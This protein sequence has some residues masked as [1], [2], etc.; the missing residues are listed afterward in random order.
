MGSR[1]KDLACPLVTGPS[2]P[3][4]HAA[5]D[6]PVRYDFAFVYGFSGCTGMRSMNGSDGMSGTSGTMGSMDPNNPSPG[7]NG[8]DGTNGSDG[9]EGSLG[10][11]AP[12]VDVRMALQ[13]GA[14]P[15]L[16]VSVSAPGHRRVYLVDPQ[17]VM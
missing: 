14:H 15:L 9:K 17:G 10:G 12:P 13:P 8:S 11:K 6:V 5:L 16:Q 3:N 7:G 4:L 1:L 2:Q